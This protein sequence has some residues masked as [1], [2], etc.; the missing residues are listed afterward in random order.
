MPI[1]PTGGD[2]ATHLEN[3]LAPPTTN[4][5]LVTF[6]EDT[7]D[8]HFQ[9]LPLVITISHF[10]FHTGTNGFLEDS[11]LVTTPYQLLGFS[12]ADYTSTSNIL[13]SGAINLVG[14]NSSSFEI[15]CGI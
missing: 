15:D 3:E 6:D 14:P 10:E 13:T 11:S 2:L 1:I 8:S 5:D 7:K 12:S 9:I 4:V